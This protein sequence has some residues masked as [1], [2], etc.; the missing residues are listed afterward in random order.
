MTDADADWLGTKVGFTLK[1]EGNGTEISF[2]HTGWK[3]ANGHF[4]QSSFCWALYL[5]ILRKFAEE[6]LHVPYSERYHF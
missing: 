1:G 6:G 3:S 2:Y 4:R 5:R